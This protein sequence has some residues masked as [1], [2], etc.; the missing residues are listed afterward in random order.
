MVVAVNCWVLRNKQLDGIGNFTVETLR[1]MMVQH[2][3]VNFMLMVDRNYR[4]AYFDFPNVTLHRIF[5]ALR[6]P[7]LYVWYM[8]TV[9]RCFL[10][11]NKPD[12]FLSMDGFLSLFS[13]TKQLPVIYDLNF[14]HYPHDLKFKN[15][16]YYRTFFKRFAKKASRIATISDFSKNDI[17]N[18]YG[19]SENKIDNVSCGIKKGFRVL[20]EAEKQEVKSRF[21]ISNDYFFFVGSMHPRKNIVRLIRAF[22]LF[23]KETASEIK[24]VLA[25]HIMWDD[26]SIKAVMSEVSVANDIHF[27]GRVSDE[28]LVGLLGAAFGLTFVPTFEGFGL[29]IVEAFQAGVPVIASNTTS[30][31]EVA[32]DAALLVNPFNENEIAGALKK[33]YREVAVRNELIAKG[34]SQK[35]LFTWER[36]AELLFDCIKRVG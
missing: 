5:P 10:K 28:E 4:E 24:L 11:K 32:G 23:K 12:L 18:K 15:R 19:I 22:D 14:E 35:A 6:H 8:E 2:P 17:I 27:T 25:G 3:E 7:V 9:V 31:P 29:P 21:G 26:S 33:L 36:T 34:F 13:R 30:M 1:K 20:D 16:L